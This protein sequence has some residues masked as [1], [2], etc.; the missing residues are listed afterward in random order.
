MVEVSRETKI[1]ALRQSIKHWEKNVGAEK[2]GLASVDGSSCALCDAYRATF[3]CFGCP[4]AQETGDHFCSGSPYDK[5]SDAWD[6]WFAYPADDEVRANFRV[7][8]QQELDFLRGLLEK[9][10]ARSED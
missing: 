3:D 9:E 2:V 6:R 5:A 1:E 7:A 4:V 10:L 8:A